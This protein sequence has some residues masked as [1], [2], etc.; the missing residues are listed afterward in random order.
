MSSLDAW[1]TLAAAPGIGPRTCA[2]LIARFGSPAGVLSARPGALADLGLKSP[3]IAA[4]QRPDRDWID[5]VLA[6]ADQ[7]DAHVLTPD[8]P[9]YPPLLGE[10]PD[11]PIVVYVRG[12]PRLLAEPQV[13]I[14]GSRNPTPPG[15]KLPASSPA[16]SLPLVWSSPAAWRPRVDGE[17]HAG[18]LET[19]RTIA[20]LGT[21]PDRVYPAG[22]RDLARRIAV[23]E[24]WSASLPPA[25]APWPRTSRAATASSPACPWAPWSPKRPCA[26]A[27]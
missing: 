2:R 7:P 4:L 12:D 25:K 5:S 23:M 27:R 14:V 13:A 9:R 20:V 18:A 26:A 10:I 19:G 11:P 17:A 6:W 1:L 16:S 3:G 8:D 15:A 21:G 22:H 24:H